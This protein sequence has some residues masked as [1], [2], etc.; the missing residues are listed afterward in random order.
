M[1]ISGT[2]PSSVIVGQSYEK[3][4]QIRLYQSLII[5]LYLFHK[6]R[7]QLARIY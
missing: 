4:N 5:I 7:I 3:K 1:H 6:Y 2:E